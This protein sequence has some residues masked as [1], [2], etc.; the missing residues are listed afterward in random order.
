[1]FSLFGFHFLLLRLCF[2]ILLLLDVFL[3]PLFLLGFLVGE[4]VINEV[5]ESNDRSDQA[6][7]VHHQHLVIRVHLI[8]CISVEA[9]PEDNI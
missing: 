7:N 5:M 3:L 2:V 1:M 9:Q 4:L 6:C 8:E